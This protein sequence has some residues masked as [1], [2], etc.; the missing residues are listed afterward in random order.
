[1]TKVV[2]RVYETDGSNSGGRVRA[3]SGAWSEATTWNSRPSLGTVHATLDQRVAKGNWYDIELPT[4]VV[5]QDGAIDLGF[6][7][8]SS[9]AHVWASRHTTTP[10]Q[11]LVTVSNG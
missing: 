1:V 6:D 10:P 2:A 5:T 9:D 7:T 11:L 8:L 3:V 4:S